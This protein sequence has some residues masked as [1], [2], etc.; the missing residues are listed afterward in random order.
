MTKNDLVNAVA[1]HWLSKR[2][3]SSVVESVF[4]NIFRCFEKSEDVKIVDDQRG[5]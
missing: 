5:G 3:S 4:E 1:A 2:L